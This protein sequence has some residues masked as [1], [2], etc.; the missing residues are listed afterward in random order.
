MA[1]S[2]AMARGP[3]RGTAAA[4]WPGL[5]PHWPRKTRP[6]AHAPHPERMIPMNAAAYPEEPSWLNPPTTR[7]VQR[8]AS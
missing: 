4:G 8:A 2:R 1:R 6:G 5:V 3:R 7:P